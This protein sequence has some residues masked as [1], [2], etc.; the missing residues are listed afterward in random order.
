MKVKTHH[1]KVLGYLG[2]DLNYG[3]SSGAL[4]VW[5]IKYLTKVL[6]EC[7]E[8]LRGSKMNPHLDNLCVIRNKDDRELLLREM[9]SWFHQTVARLL[10]LYMRASPHIQT[11]VSFLTTRVKS[12]DVDDWGKLR[13][14]LQ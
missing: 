9:A 13:H 2:M 3:S 6:E 8:K 11:T 12:P 7:P 4:L 1:G 5:I 10:F 14:C